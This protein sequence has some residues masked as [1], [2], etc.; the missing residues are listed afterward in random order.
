MPYEVVS[1]CK[2]NIVRHF[3]LFDLRFCDVMG[4]VHSW[5]RLTVNPLIKGN[6]LGRSF[7]ILGPVSQTVIKVSQDS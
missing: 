4:S 5:Y 7:N 6:K 1:Y 3:Q 2:E